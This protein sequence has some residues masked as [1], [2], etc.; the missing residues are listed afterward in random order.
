MTDVLAS[1]DERR[2]QP[3]GGERAPGPFTAPKLALPTGGGAHRGIGETFQANA[4]NGTATFTVPIATSPGRG[5]FGPALSLSYDSGSGNGPFGLGW[6]LAVPA[7]TRKTDKGIPRYED[8]HDSDT[9]VLSGSEDLV[10]VLVR[11]AATGAWERRPLPRT[12]GTEHY[13]VERFRPRVESSFAR[14]ERW[15][16]S[17]GTVFW[18]SITRDNLTS[19]FGR[20]NNSRIVDP[21]DPDPAH[22]TRVFSW[23]LCES[24][25]DRGNAIVYTYKEDDDTGVDAARPEERNRD[26]TTAVNRYLKT[27]RYGN[28]DSALTTPNLSG[29]D[30]MFEVVFDYG[31]HDAD[32]PRPSDAGDWL[33]RRDAFST[34]RS[35]FEVRTRRLCQR[36]LMFHHFAGAAG[37]GRNCLVR[38]TD[39]TYNDADT[40]PAGRGRGDPVVSCLTQAT[41]RGYRRNGTAYVARALAPLEFDYSPVAIDDTVRTLDEASQLH[42]PAGVDERNYRFVDLDGEGIAGIL[43]QQQ[44]A[45]Y[46]K[47]S[48]GAARFA[49]AALVNPAPATAGGQLLDLDGDGRLEL[50]SYDGAVPGFYERTL[51]GSWEQFSAFAQLPRIPWQ[52]PQLRFVDLDG[53]GFA[54][55]LIT[56]HEALGWHPSLGTRGFGERRRVATARDEELGPRVVFG[57]GTESVYLAD[58]SGDGLSDLV[59]VRNGEICYWPNLGY[60]RFGAKVTMADAPWF[61]APDTFDQRRVKLAD[62][63]GSGTTD[64]IYLGADGTRLYFNQAGNGWSPPRRL[65]QSF[66]ADHAASVTTTDLLGSGTTCLVWSSPL[67]G[68]ARAPLR[69]MDLLGGHKPHLLVAMR[70]NRGLETRVRYASSTAFYLA[71]KAAGRPWVTRLAFP[72]QVIDRVETVDRIARTRFVSRFA[73]HHGCFD[74]LE[75]EFRGFGLIEQRDTEEFAVLA[76]TGTL[77]VGANIAAA[78]H[79]PPVL[80]RTWYHTGMFF[81]GTT[82][83][84]QF[85]SEYYREPGL[86]PAQHAAQLLPDTTLPAGLEVGELADACRALKGQLLR[87]EVYAED[88][89][90]RASRPYQVTESSHEV[91]RLQPRGAGRHGAFFTHP[92]ETVNLQ[93]ERALVAPDPTD[94]STGVADPRITHEFTLRVDDLGNV[95]RVATIAYPRRDVP[96]RIAEQTEQHVTFT[97]NRFASRPDEADWYRIGMPIETHTWEVARHPLASR[98][99]LIYRLFDFEDV[100]TRFEGLLPPAAVEPAAAQ[101]LDPTWWDWRYD[102][103]APAGLRLRLLEQVRTLYRRDTLTGARPL[104]EIDSMGLPYDELRLAFT[105]S[106]VSQ[107]FET[108]VSGALLTGDAGYVQ[109]AGDTGYWLPAGRVFYSED[110]ADNAATELAFARD[111]FFQPRRYRDPLGAE[112]TLR[113]DDDDLLIRETEDALGN[114][115]TA[116][117]RRVDGTLQSSSLD[118][119]VLQPALVMDPNRNRA[120]V[121]FD[122]LGLVTATAVMGKPGQTLGDSVAGIDPDPPLADVRAHFDNPFAGANALLGSASTRMLYDRLAY[123]DTRDDPQPRPVAAYTLAREIHSADLAAGETSPL[124][125][126]FVYADGQG[127]PFQRKRQAERGPLVAGGPDVR[128]WAGSGWTVVD[129]KGR[130]V[131]RYEPFFTATHRYEF[132][133]RVGAS[134][135]RRYDPLDR[136]ALALHADHSYEK[137]TFDAWDRL[138]WDANDTVL[139]TDPA[140]DP[141]V[142]AWFALLPASDYLDTWYTQRQGGALGSEAQAAATQV[143]V[144]HDTPTN[145][146]HDALGRTVRVLEHNR[147]FLNGL[148]TEDFRETRSRFDAENNLR[149]IRDAQGRIVVIDDYD[150][151]GRR[152]RHRSMDAGERR[153]LIDATGRAI[154]SWDSRSHAMRTAY[155]ALGRP[156]DVF[157]RVGTAAERL[158]QQVEYGETEANPEPDNLRGRTVRIRDGAGLVEQDRYDFKGNLLRSARTFAEQYR[159]VLNWQADPPLETETFTTETD[160]DALNRP[161]AIRLPDGTS[162]HPS[163]NIANLLDAISANIRGAAT[164]TTIVRDIDYN[165]RGQRTRLRWGNDAETI[166][167]YDPDT[168][169]VVQLATTRDVTDYPDDCPDPSLRGCGAQRLRYWYDPSGSVAAV[170][171]DAQSEIFFRNRRI[172]PAWTYIYDALHRLIEARGREHLGQNIDGSPRDPSPP[173]DVLRAPAPHPAERLAFGRYTERYGYDDAGNLETITHR[174]ADPASPGWT[175]TSRYR[176]A[177]LIEPARFGNRLTSSAVNSDPQQP[178]GHDEHG[179]VNA[180]PHLSFMQ[181]DYLD[182]LR[183]TARGVVTGGIPETTWYVYDSTG[184]RVRK[185]TDGKLSAAAV[186]AGSTPVARRERRYLGWYEVEREY[187]AGGAVDVERQSVMIKVIDPQ[188]AMPDDNDT[189][190]P[191]SPASAGVARP[192]PP[193]APDE[194]LVIIETATIGPDA[195]RRLTRYQL[196][197]RQGSVGTELDAAGAIVSHEE[198]Y[199]FGGTSWQAFPGTTQA[200]KRHRFTGREHDEESGFTRHGARYCAA[201]LGRWISAD[202]SGLVDGLNV[203]A[204]ARNNPVSLSDT[205]GYAGDDP[206]KPDAGRPVAEGDKKAPPPPAAHVILLGSDMPGGGAKKWLNKMLNTDTVEDFRGRIKAGDSLVVM[207]A[208]GASKE[209][210]EALQKVLKKFQQSKAAVVEGRIV[211]QV[212]VQ[213][214]EV[215]GKDVAKE[216]NKLSNI[217]TLAYVGHGTGFSGPLYEFVGSPFPQPSEFQ[218]DRFSKEAVGLFASCNLA[219]YAEGFTKQTGLVSLGVEGTTWFGADSI[220]AGRLDHGDPGTSRMFMFQVDSDGNIVKSQPLSINSSGLPIFQSTKPE[221]KRDPF[222]PPWP[223]IH[224]LAP[225]PEPKPT[226]KK[227]R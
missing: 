146:Q 163:Y 68:D 48:L 161:G 129:N 69:Y 200:T 82:I 90:P 121:L 57:D 49:Q 133:R 141:D 87:R 29:S 195:P 79:A 126:G 94:P 7:I 182:R 179:N 166:T 175:R 144:H 208:P 178:F 51:E 11:N 159:E 122:A 74:G 169:R 93:Y 193:A 183:A 174:G 42:A 221:E 212:S 215:H 32:R 185:V 36:I 92:R 158:V 198:F 113:Y 9:F 125:H 123:T 142:G 112:T 24:R 203:F 38:S 28:R 153:M 59:R 109:P 196:A 96:G 117:V 1:Q 130:P 86:T 25:D 13:Q 128:R 171:D 205:G 206:V 199:P 2:Q 106:L 80:T 201:W 149:E 180:A 70:N 12:I 30:W 211:A 20:D 132:D 72:V 137:T 114:L 108:R 131:R 10:P 84:R 218:K 127:R 95:E 192:Q 187:G 104:G 216:V 77:A 184:E 167:D 219:G 154:R 63:D 16:A 118:Y 45:W 26:A 100:R 37:V 150:L 210:K 41:Q 207:M 52:D 21:A 105:P 124:Q 172:E 40:T 5:G 46:Y 157:L 43:T 119:R 189:E 135:I 202:P 66:R 162:V 23:L 47:A 61:D 101:T 102:T 173:G 151:L 39:F 110:P 54:D 140:A 160:F 67:P 98:L 78:T 65:A 147:W 56:E 168:F 14:I 107:L 6:S 99:G 97:V 89:T 213:L 176:T 197:D 71:D 209:D 55:V 225:K 170:R 188:P 139:T 4:V 19:W 64:I 60:G 155:D 76:A 17:D 111:H 35:G 164:R 115:V 214:K 186:A 18:R 181:W 177:S 85:E 134:E 58:M 75:R 152:M 223:F 227:K 156:T 83:S 220:S 145:D 222:R 15:T 204:Y 22:T 194:T 143:A 116:G 81:G 191:Q 62:L 31:E 120:A 138:Q 103:A 224:Q 148:T 3:A 33:C 88:G 190:S 34:F 8:A 91:R 44:G 217:E 27:I 50:A 136:P 73:Y 165:A 226:P 53:D